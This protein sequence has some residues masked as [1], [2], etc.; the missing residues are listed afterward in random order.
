MSYYSFAEAVKGYERIWIFGDDFSFRSLDRYFVNRSDNL[1][2]YVHDT[3]EI[4]GYVNNEYNSLDR[5]IL[6]RMQNMLVNAITEQKLFPRFILIVMDNDIMKSLNEDVTKSQSNLEKVMN[7]LMNEH[8]RIVETYKEH[9]QQKAK[10][11][12]Y[13]YFIWIQAPTHVNFRDN[14]ER[15]RFNQVI[16]RVSK[17]HDNTAVLALKKI[18]D[19]QNK[20][21]YLE[22]ENRY[23]TDGLRFYW[24]AVDKTVKYADTILFKKLQAQKL[25]KC[26][27]GN[28]SESSLIGREA[29][30]YRRKFKSN[31]NRYD[32]YHWYSD[33]QRRRRN[34]TPKR[35]HD[36]ED[37]RKH[38]KHEY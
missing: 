24:E 14:A 10:K 22:R 18:W 31:Y 11:D 3:L 17:L 33:R 7:W 6:S 25:K 36:K 27:E 13:P 37:R 8:S 1:Q 23:T 20:S 34:S 16:E 12:F 21:L 32:K 9:L 35:Q 4:N 26:K 28:A 19:P 29:P 30:S 15:E 5:S 2:G 38:C